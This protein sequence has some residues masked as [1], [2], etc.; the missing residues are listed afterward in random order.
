MLRPIEQRQSVTQAV[1]EQI[2]QAMLRGALNPGDQLPSEPILADSL[3]VSRASVREAIKVLNALGVL[4]IRRGEGTFVASQ[5]SPAAINPILSQFIAWR[6]IGRL[7]KLIEFRYLFECSYLE[8]VV[9]R[10]TEEKMIRLKEIHE[11]ARRLVEMDS[12][13][14]EGY[15]RLDIEFHIAL[16]E[17]SDNQFVV[18]M[19]RMLMDLFAVGIDE[20]L[21]KPNGMKRSFA[22]HEEIIRLLGQRDLQALRQVIKTSLEQIHE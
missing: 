6:G 21:L 7:E 13:D 9:E 12:N 18:S 1:V 17:S 15:K 20:F 3:K 10:L 8:L 19:G 11:R 2:K 14:R 22:S 4:E 5:V 16:L